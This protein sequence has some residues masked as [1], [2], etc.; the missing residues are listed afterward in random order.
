MSPKEAQYLDPQQRLTLETAW[1]AL[2]HAGIDP[3]GLRHGNGGVYIGVSCVDYPLEAESLAYEEL[4]PYVGTGTSHSVVPGR[5]SYFLGWRGPCLAIDTACSS[6]LVA[7][8][9]AAGG[10]RAGECD[11]ALAGGVNAIHHPR[12]HIVFTQAG[13]LSPDGQCKTFDESADGYGRSEGCGVLVLKRLSDAKRAG[14]RIIALVRGSAVR[15]DGE[16]GGLTVPNGSAQEA[17]MRAALSRS[18]LAPGDIGY[19]EAHGTGTPLGDPIEMRAIRSVFAG[20]RPK[21]GRS[22]S[23]VGQ[24]QRRP[25]GGGGGHRRR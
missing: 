17:V 6:S 2:E 20:A 16:S 23:G 7:L 10:L 4:D 21:A 8:H 3:T 22:W 13:M 14:D 12:N 19:V 18:M 25:H 15:Q 1:E 5:L 24:D 11:I 9:L